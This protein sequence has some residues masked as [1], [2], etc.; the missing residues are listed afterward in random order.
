MSYIGE[1]NE[2]Q[3]PPIRE[4]SKNKEEN[5]DFYNKKILKENVKIEDIPQIF[6][7]SD[8][9]IIALS[10][11]NNLNEK[12]H[13]VRVMMQDAKEYREAGL[14]NKADVLENLR[15]LVFGKVTM[16]E[17]IPEVKFTEED[18]EDYEDFS[19]PVFVDGEEEVRPHVYHEE[20]LTKDKPNSLKFAVIA[21]VMIT[22]IAIGK[23]INGEREIPGRQKVVRGSS[24]STLTSHAGL[25][26]RSKSGYEREARVIKK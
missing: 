25:N 15:S 9:Y 23:K 1:G 13:I 11:T 14:D 24:V 6:R 8:L 4:N 12:R 18:D 16:Q 10:N 2:V 20:P 26:P 22:A 19:R 17:E 3:A 5:Q 21:G 7:T